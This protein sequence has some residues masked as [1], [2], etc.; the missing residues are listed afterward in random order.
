MSPTATGIPSANI[1]GVIVPATAL[2]PEQV[3]RILSGQAPVYGSAT[4]IP[5]RNDPDNRRT[6]RFYSAAFRMQ[7]SLLPAAGVQASYQRVHTRRIYMNGPGGTGSQPLVPNYSRFI[8]DIDTVDLR[9]N[10]D[11]TGWN[12]FTAGYEFEMESYDEIQDNNL[13]SPQRIRTQTTIGQKANAVY[14]QDQSSLL[15]GSLQLSLS[16]RLQSFSLEKPAFSATGVANNYDRVQLRAPRKAATGDVSLSYFYSR[17][18]TKVR[19]HAGNAYRAP[20]LFE[21]FGG[22]FFL[23]ATTGLLVFSPY[24]DPFLTPDRYN[25]VDAGIDQYVW[26]D[27]IRISSTYFYSRVVTITA[28]DL[29]SVINAA[30]DP[31]GRSS[32]YIN[33]SGGASRGVE[34]SAD[35]RPSG[36][37]ALRGSYTYTKAAMD[38][39]VTVPGF[40]RVL[41]VPRHASTL[42]FTQR[43]GERA[44]LAFDLTHNSEVFGNFTAAGR[45]RAYRYDG[46]VKADIAGYYDLRR[47]DSGALRFSARVDN[48]FN[49]TIYDLGWLAPGATF[50][51]GLSFQY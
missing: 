42:V 12:Q 4:F 48:V 33:G 49:R 41:G 8:G 13:P 39:D 38:R 6:S 25:S 50:V 32:G 29:G 34:L 36:G 21:R 17:T 43:V 37:M 16:G 15:A 23:N 1:T 9:G 24:G 46:F 30:T 35:I 2:P 51:T 14:F 40:W 3:Q 22:G 45:P 28:F 44:T 26:R 31:Y 47:T 20:G 11:L 18:G 27:R 10:I 7:H 5:G 19:A